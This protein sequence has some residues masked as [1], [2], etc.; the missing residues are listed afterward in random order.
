[1]STQREEETVLTTLDVALGGG[2]AEMTTTDVEKAMPPLPRPI[3][4]LEEL[5]EKMV[6]SGEQ[7]RE[8]RV[9][10]EHVERDG[11][12]Q[13]LGEKIWK[14][15]RTRTRTRTTTNE[16]K[17]AVVDEDPVRVGRVFTAVNEGGFAVLIGEELRDKRSLG[18]V[19]RAAAAAE[20]EKKRN[21]ED[22]S[23]KK[24]ETTDT[25][26]TT[27]TTTTKNKKLTH[28]PKM[29][30]A[31]LESPVNLGASDG[32][33]ARVVCLVLVPMS[34]QSLSLHGNNNNN[35]DDEDKSALFGLDCWNKIA[36]IKAAFRSFARETDFVSDASDFKRLHSHA[37][38]HSRLPHAFDV[39]SA[40]MHG[41]AR[42]IKCAC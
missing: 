41:I 3:R 39:L 21:E 14:N 12:I 13:F 15:A 11:N 5:K 28:V 36:C 10:V 42:M 38:K 18:L 20:A 16:E 26:T 22:A 24:E 2:A 31:T 27:T 7:I 6:E 17:D 1:M 40:V 34:S 33:N 35:D 30:I 8:H 23:A 37:K 4:V 25:T 29:A 9:R 32:R 19:V